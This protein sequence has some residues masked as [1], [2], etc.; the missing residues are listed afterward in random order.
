M[1]RLCTFWAQKTKKQTKTASNFFCFFQ[2]CPN[3]RTWVSLGNFWQEAVI[4]WAMECNDN[5][6]GVQWQFTTDKARIKLD[7]IYT[8]F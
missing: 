2:N 7:S 6:K 4:V 1:I 3:C 5:Q 8:K